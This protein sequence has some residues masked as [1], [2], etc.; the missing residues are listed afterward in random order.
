MT[1]LTFKPLIRAGIFLGIG[2]GGFFDG[3]VFHQLLQLHNML[4]GKL[5]KDSITNIEVNMFWDGLFHA[6][7][8]TMTLIGLILLWRAVTKA[9][10]LAPSGSAWNGVSRR[11]QG[12]ILLARSHH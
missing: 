10:A 11:H 6:G 8:W 7:T 4:T 9:P 12:F 3:I 1:Q 5:P 2:M